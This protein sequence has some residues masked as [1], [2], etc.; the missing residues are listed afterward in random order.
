M[1]KETLSNYGWIVIC[2]L[3]LAVMIAL[4]GPFGTFV[5]GAVK[6]T[7]AGLFGV[8]QNALGAAGIEIGDQAFANCEHL[9]IEIRNATAD[10]SGDTCCKECGTILSTGT[11]VVPEGGKYIAAD[12]TV[13][14]PGDGFPE[15]VTTGDQ[16]TYGD[17]QYRYNQYWAQANTW[18]TRT[19]DGWGV[20]CI[21]NVAEPGPI[22]ETINGKPI[23]D[24]TYTFYNCGEMVIAPIIPDTVTNMDYAFAYRNKLVTVPNI[25]RDVKSLYSTFSSCYALETVGDLSQCS[26]LTSMYYAFNGCKSLKCDI[27]LPDSVTTLHCAFSGCTSLTTVR[28]IP[29]GTVSMDNAFANCTSLTGTILVNAE[30]RSWNMSGAFENVNFETQ[31]ITL[32]GTSSYIDTMGAT[33]TNYCAECNG[34]CKGG[35]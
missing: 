23:K 35:H 27:N 26:Q 29:S 15:T 3:V 8:N 11:Y 10:Y 17:Y 14:N 28:S 34:C 4:A 7:T 33:G 19:Q 16:Y 2:V 9:E 12:G 31:N 5:A 22:L 21:N 18:A 24:L 30:P 13:Y 20:R 1:D 6:S 32:I 25:P